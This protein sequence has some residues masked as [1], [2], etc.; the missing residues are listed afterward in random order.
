MTKLIV[1]AEDWASHPSSTQHLMPYIAAGYRRYLG[2]LH[3]HA[4]AFIYH[5]RYPSAVAEGY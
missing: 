4:S 1:F 3:W 2:E 5:Q